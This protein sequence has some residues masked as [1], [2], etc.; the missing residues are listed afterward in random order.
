MI[1]HCVIYRTLL[2]ESSCI[3]SEG[4][5]IDWIGE[6]RRWQ[7]EKNGLSPLFEESD[8]AI[9]NEIEKK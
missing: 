3:F 1:T 2:L 7:K 9:L 4:N 8:C 5:D 6:K